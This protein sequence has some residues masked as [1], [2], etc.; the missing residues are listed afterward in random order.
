MEMKI[1]WKDVVNIRQRLNLTQR[2]FARDNPR[3]VMVAVRKARVRFPGILPPIDARTCH[4]RPRGS[5][6]R[7]YVPLM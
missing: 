1:C 2:Q 7:K 4:R 6:R 3:A 5:G